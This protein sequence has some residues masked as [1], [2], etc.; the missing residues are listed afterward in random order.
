MSANALFTPFELG[1]LT[2][3]NRIVMAPLTRAR[4]GE[5]RLPN[6]I[7]AEYYAQ[8]SSAGL[9]I[10]EATTISEQANGW[11]ESPGIYTDEMEERWKL[12]TSSVHEKG[13]RIFLQLWHM[14]RASHSSFHNGELP[15]APSAVRLN[16]DYIHTPTG[17]QPYEVPRAL[18]T[19]EIPGIVEDYRRAAERAQAA[20]FDGVEIHAA[21]GYLIDQFLQSKT[22]HR[23]DQYGGSI[24]NRYRF[25]DEVVEAVTSVWPSTR[26]GV[27]LSP[28]GS[29]N[30][31]GSPD[32]REQFTYAA[33]QLNRYGLGYLHVLD[34][35][36]FGV[37]GLGE[38][39]TLEDFRKVFDGPLMGN[40]SYD[41]DSAARAI[42]EGRAELIAFGRKFISNPD[43]VERF[44]NGWPLN[45]DADM[46]VWYATTGAKGYTDFP[47]YRESRHEATAPAS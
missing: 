5:E 12:I 42:A 18:E 35:E 43:L 24:E 13:G 29:F 31:M 47:T 7:M 38:P 16:E 30:D 2:L 8:R 40:G 39:M 27:R 1:D 22:N 34:G 28:N 15:V 23:T 36:T 3:S 26:V 44:R 4:A 17:K 37:H 33:G 41:R 20:G 14:G 21:N 46:S 32:Y 19:D 6:E 9:I 45:D 11:N 10:S 25:L